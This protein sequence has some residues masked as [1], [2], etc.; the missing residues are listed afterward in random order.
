TLQSLR[1]WEDFKE[2][3]AT[4]PSR[5]DLLKKIRETLKEY[6]EALFLESS[7]ARIPSPDARTLKAFEYNFFHALRGDPDSFPTLGGSSVSIYDDA[8]D[9]VALHT[10]EPVDRMSSF[11]SLHITLGFYSRYDNMN[12]PTKHRK[13]FY[14]SDQK[15]SRFVAWL[16]TSTFL[17]VL[18]L[19]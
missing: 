11:N 9:L 15:L 6:R 5:I 10:V 8:D 3:S 1:N 2:R 19:V 17:A 13:L 7:L 12:T 16:S 18:L 4:D 14:T